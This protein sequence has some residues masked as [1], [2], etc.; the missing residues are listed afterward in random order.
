MKKLFLIPL[1]ACFSC[2]MA[3][4]T[5]RTAG[6]Y[7]EL[8]DALT[9]ADCDE[10]QL[11]ADF[12]YP[13]NGSGLI[14]ITKSV[15][16]DGQ[17]HTISGYGSRGGNNTTIAINQGGANFVAV[18]LKDLTIR[19]AGAAGRPI[20]CRGKM[21]SLTLNNVK[22][23]AT[24]SGN[25]QGITI[26]GN[27]A[28]AMT[29]N[30]TNSLIDVTQRNQ[31]GEITKSGSYAIISFNPYNAT[32]DHCTFYAWAGLY[33]REPSSSAGS[34]G[35]VVNVENT[36]F[37][38]SNYNS[39]E[40]NSFGGFVCQDDGITITATNCTMESSALGDQAQAVL[41]A[42]GG[43]MPAG[44]RVQPISLTLAGDNTRIIMDGAY[45]GNVDVKAVKTFDNNT[46]YYYDVHG[47]GPQGY[48]IV[49]FSVTMTGGTYDVNPMY[50]RHVT[51][52]NR[53]G[54]G[55][56]IMDGDK[57]SVQTQSPI[58]PAGY[59]I[60]T[61]KD[62]DKTLYRV[63]KS[64]VS[65]DI[66]GQY[67]TSEAGENPTTS[68]VVETT[69][70]QP[71][72]LV[73][74]ETKAAYVQ[75]RDNGDGDATVL[76]VGK[77]ENETPVDQT[78]IVNNGLDVQGESQVVVQSG[79]TLQIGEGGIVTEKPENIVI[80]ADE[81]GAASLIMDPAITVNQTPNLTVKMKAKQIGWETIAGN[82]H[83]FWHRFA[84]PIQE[85]ATWGKYPNKS[86]YVYG[87]NYTT[88]DWEQYGALTQ[89]V[90][91]QG[92]TLSADYE[93][94]GDVEYTFTGQ[95]AGNTNNALEFQRNGYNFF[96]NSYTG[97]ISILALVDQLTGDNKID[98][99]VW[100]WNSENQ[101]YFGVPLKGLRD[102]P[103][104]YEDWQKEIA[105]MQTFILKQNGAENASTE[106]NYASA[107][108]GNPRYNNV[109]APAPRRAETDETT[110][111]RI[112]VTA[113][114]GK[115]DF[116]MF[117][118]DGKFTDEYENGYDASK[119][120]NEGTLNLFA[121]VNGENYTA[122]ATDNLEGKT[123]TLNTNDEIAYTISFKKVNGEEYALRDNAT[124]K[125]IAIE[126]GATYEF[127]AQPNSTVEGRFEI[128][129]AAKM[130]T[131]I[132]NTE[133]K[134]NAKGIY[135]LTGQYLGEDFEAVPAGVYVVNGVKI[136][137]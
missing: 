36:A 97:Y 48:G 39:G 118:E 116:V 27:Q 68:F 20:E 7:Q 127:A 28:T 57:Y 33:F 134:A 38:C 89:M 58:I 95:L 19:N 83:Y 81:N 108:W 137:K 104:A 88:N 72:E 133:V 112:V 65:Y 41:L 47:Y 46:W 130:P 1:M 54:D 50:Y 17:N 42:S 31:A 132:E 117:T 92:Y 114:N 78:L 90:P 30:M 105:P 15:T 107:V 22:V 71:I 29:L 32:I 10:I 21:T 12:G 74:N 3:F 76:K 18:T 43:Y 79:S 84:L 135:T 45:Y 64:D 13:T 37:H 123:L 87:W 35:S 128:V 77:V 80:N 16:I 124:N 126:E 9:D 111:M 26:G 6:T 23:Y 4:A 55:N 91:F 11:T 96:G 85:C 119:Y 24:G 93:H 34:R 63:T 66:N 109:A 129:A 73:N 82:K 125:V 14:N 67:E 121:T 44:R 75:V 86:T 99:S 110:R 94:L 60:V 56:P 2:V 52:V 53:D 70:D 102:N 69:D 122:V 131:A 100:V 8:Q 59:A 98:G 136:V 61:V 113:Q 103:E 5:V 101:A 51:A 120:I 49:P 115:S 25:C 40:T 62:G 106:L